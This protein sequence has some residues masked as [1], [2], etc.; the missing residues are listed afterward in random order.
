MSN[1]SNAEEPKDLM[2]KVIIDDAEPNGVKVSKKNICTVTIVQ[3]EKLQKELEERS[4]LMEYFVESQ[5]A[6]FY[7]QFIG[8]V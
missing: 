6:T 3:S 7:S 2:F 5:D 1:N 8:A 4:K